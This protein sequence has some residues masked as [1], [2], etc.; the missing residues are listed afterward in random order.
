MSNEMMKTEN[1]IPAN[2]LRLAVEQGADIEKLEKLMDLQERWDAKES[3]KAFLSAMAKFQ[4]EAPVLLKKTGVDY[5]SQKSGIRVRYNFADLGQISQQIKKPLFDSGLSYR[6]EIQEDN[7]Q[8]KVKC[9][10]SHIDGHS[11]STSM[12]A[13]ADTSGGKNIIQAHGSTLTYMERYTLLGVLGIVTADEDNDA[14]TPVE[15]IDDKQT[16]DILAMI[17]SSKTKMDQF[18]QWAGCESLELMPSS[19]YNNAVQ[20]LKKKV[21]RAKKNT[22]KEGELL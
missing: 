8:I 9:I 1:S 15:Y 17:D 2:L 12:S 6:F 19:L 21:S 4:N 18:L 11:E 3:K 16:A 20:L 5:T 13:P 14:E 10:A 7:N 22:V